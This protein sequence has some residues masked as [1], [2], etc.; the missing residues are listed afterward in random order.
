MPGL[1]AFA[2][3]ATASVQEVS[4][5]L[6]TLGYVTRIVDTPA[7]TLIEATYTIPLGDSLSYEQTIRVRPGPVTA[8]ETNPEVAR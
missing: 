5:G 4:H 2:F 8:Q 6:Q 3:P 1:P 7:C